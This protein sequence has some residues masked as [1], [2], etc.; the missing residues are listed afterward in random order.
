VFRRRV[1][2]VRSRLL[3]MVLLL[4]SSTLTPSVDCYRLRNHAT[5]WNNSWFLKVLLKDW[6]LWSY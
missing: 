6:L 2:G 5:A 1:L 3:E 4:A